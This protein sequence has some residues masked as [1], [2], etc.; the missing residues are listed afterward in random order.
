MAGHSLRDAGELSPPPPTSKPELLML[1]LYG[2]PKLRAILYSI[3][4][5]IVVRDQQKVLIF[6]TYRATELLIYGA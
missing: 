5:D 3:I 4:I 1:L 6:C 2:A